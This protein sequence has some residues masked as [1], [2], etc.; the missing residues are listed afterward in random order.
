MRTLVGENAELF[1]QLLLMEKGEHK[2]LPGLLKVFSLKVNLNKGLPTAVKY[3]FPDILPTILPKY[4]I[5]VSINPNWLAGF[6][7]AEGSFYIS[8]YENDKRKA[9]YAVSLSFSLSQQ[10]K[11]VE[12]LER[13]SLFLDCG[14]VR[15]SPNRGTAELIIT[16]SSDLNQ[17]VIPLLLKYNLSGVKLL[18]F[19]RFKEVSLLISAP[20]QACGV[21]S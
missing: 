15:R 3:K 9:G 20:P 7:T 10:V 17:K 19:E 13:L 21:A 12:L 6:I 2:T 11:V 14:V 8:L 4:I 1:T 16:K 5:P 18:D